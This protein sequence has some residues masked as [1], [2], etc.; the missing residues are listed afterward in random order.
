[1]VSCC[2]AD[3]IPLQ[4]AIVDA[5]RELADDSWVRVVARW[6]PPPTTYQEL[7]PPWLVE[8]GITEL[9]VLSGAPPD[10]YESPY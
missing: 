5:G 3:G 7:E 9:T 10:S 2:A 1:M 6:R 4:V 8:A